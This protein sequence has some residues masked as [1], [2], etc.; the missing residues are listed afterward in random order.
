[1]KRLG[2]SVVLYAVLVCAVQAEAS[3]VY[4]VG[5]KGPAGGFVFYDKGVFSNGWRYLEAAPGETEFVDVE[6][7]VYE[8]SVPG[9]VV[10]IGFGTRNTRLIVDF[11]EKNEENGKAAQLCAG[12][13]FGGCGDWFLPSRGELNLIY[14]NLKKKGVGNFTNSDYWSSSEYDNSNSWVQSFR[15]GNQTINSKNLT[16]SARAV[17]A[18]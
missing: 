2:I 1:M 17:R 4:T 15:D 3:G 16:C 10:D 7:G 18:F 9:I 6:W 13:N 8:K 12:L 14:Q 11:L 5:G